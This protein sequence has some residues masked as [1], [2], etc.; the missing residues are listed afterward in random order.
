M[1]PFIFAYTELLFR[2]LFNLLVAITDVLPGH[3]VGLAIIGVTLVVRLVL[4]PFTW[5]QAR[6]ARRNQTK[7]AAV[8]Q[9][10]KKLQKK[11]KDDKAQLAQATME[12]YRR[13]GVNPVSGCLPLLV[14]LPIL[15]ALYRVF[16]VGLGPDTYA[17]LYSF[18]PVPVDIN[19]HFLGLVL[20]EPSLLLGV[21]AGVGQFVMMRF[22]TPAP[23]TQPGAS[24]ETAAM[25]AKMQRN[26]MYFFPVMTV[27]IALRLPA[28][29]A[30][31]WVASTVFAIVQQ[32]I[33][34][35][36]HGS[37]GVMPVA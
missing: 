25:M 11:H 2:P 8:Q 30:L 34:R 9:E 20:T 14:Q 22:F 33:L 32:Y 17:F 21:V 10:I 29:L 6:G 16:L 3:Q 36:V 1:N 18:V 5:Q 13:E 7:M 31:Y 23:Q 37:S 19:L 28:A 15:I 12:V 24:D 27:F 4:L 26:M 35:R